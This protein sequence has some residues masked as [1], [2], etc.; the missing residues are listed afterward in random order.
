M[1]YF[2]ASSKPETG[3]LKILRLTTWQ[4]MAT[5]MMTNA[6]TMIHFSRRCNACSTFFMFSPP[7]LRFILF[8]CVSKETGAADRGCSRFSY[9]RFVLLSI[10]RSQ[11]ATLAIASSTAACH[12]GSKVKPFSSALA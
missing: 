2:A 3:I 10:R 8:S 12:S 7:E 9:V 1:E 6:I 11:L 5:T 4:K